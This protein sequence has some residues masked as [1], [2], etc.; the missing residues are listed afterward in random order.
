MGTTTT[1]TSTS[2]MSVN[3]MGNFKINNVD[4]IIPTLEDFSEEDR[5]EIQVNTEELHALM[6]GRYAKTNGD[7]VKRDTRSVTITITMQTKDGWEHEER[8]H[9]RGLDFCG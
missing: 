2:C 3:M 4:S 1:T 5:A 6:L 8:Y 9:V 7:F